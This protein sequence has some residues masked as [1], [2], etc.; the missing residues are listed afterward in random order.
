MIEEETTYTPSPPPPPS[1]YRTNT[2]S[3]DEQ[4]REAQAKFIAPTKPPRLP[5]NSSNKRNRKIVS[6]ETIESFTAAA[7]SKDVNVT[8]TIL[9][10]ILLSIVFYLL[11]H[12]SASKFANSIIVAP[13]L[14]VPAIVFVIISWIIILV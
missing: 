9:K 4:V 12:E 2:K 14:V 7:H 13:T 6:S 8:K 10:V 1:K 11:G 3:H 5:S